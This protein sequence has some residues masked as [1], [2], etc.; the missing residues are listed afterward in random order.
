MESRATVKVVEQSLSQAEAENLVRLA[1]ATISASLERAGQELLDKAGR[2][3]S[4]FVN[5]T[6]TTR[7]RVH[8]SMSGCG[9]SLAEAVIQASRRAANDKR[10]GSH[11]DNRA[12]SESLIHLWIRRGY[13]S[14]AKISEIDLGLHGVELRCG[15]R[16]AYFKPSVALTSRVLRANR[17]LEKL[18]KKAHLARGEWRRGHVELRRTYWDHFVERDPG[19]A[20]VVRLSRLRPL[21]TEPFGSEQLCRSLDLAEQRLLRVQQPDGMFLYRYHPFRELSAK[22]N[23]LVRQAGCTFALSRAIGRKPAEDKSRGL[24][25]LA[26]KAAAAALLRYR[27]HAQDNAIY[28][29]E[30]ARDLA[31]IGKLGSA[32]LLFAALQDPSVGSSFSLASQALYRWII[33]MQRSDG[34]FRCRTSSVSW[35][36]DGAAQDFFPGEALT[37]LCTTLRDNSDEAHAIIL[38]AFPWYR[39]YFRRKPSTAFILWQVEAWRLF[40]E[41]MLQHRQSDRVVEE[42]S[43]FV[44]EM[45]DWIL[46]LQ[47]GRHSG[48][49]SDFIGGFRRHNGTPHFGSAAYTEAVIRAFGLSTRLAMT[50]KIARYRSAARDGLSFVVRL[51]I[52]PETAPLF[53]DPGLAIGGTTYSLS[54]LTIRCDFDQHAITAYLAALENPGLF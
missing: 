22:E 4:N 31:A 18:S 53:A 2:C 21:C 5:V 54:N 26:A 28:L 27:I 42:I 43:T 25:I 12:L 47:L 35:Q 7:G 46:Q 34:S 17:L 6:I 51:Q 24:V 20:S 10:F 15:R 19:V 49:H 50:N 29:G 36:D 52:A 41:W 33:S 13:S 3:S 14:I 8:A 39:S 32:A 23:N 1:R 11:I 44:F 16:M 30:P 45:V 37:A 9:G 38:R 40:T 48:T